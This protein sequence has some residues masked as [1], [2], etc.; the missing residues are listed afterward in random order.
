MALLNAPIIKCFA[1]FEENSAERFELI[2]WLPC[3]YAVYWREIQLLKLDDSLNYKHNIA[4][5]QQI[6]YY[7][8]HESAY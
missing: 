2:Y 5:P 7:L 4:S 8:V 1:S 6:Y 3:R